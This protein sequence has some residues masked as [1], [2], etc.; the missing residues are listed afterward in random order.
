[1][2]GLV[3]ED[4]ICG[5]VPSIYVWRWRGSAPRSLQRRALVV[6]KFLRDVKAPHG[7][8]ES[9]AHSVVATAGALF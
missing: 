9:D 7:V 5:F 3:G 4:T 6:P 8:W 1:M 2:E